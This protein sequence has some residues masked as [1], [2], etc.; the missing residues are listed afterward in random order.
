M[1]PIEIIMLLCGI[2]FLILSFFVGNEKMSQHP[3]TDADLFSAEKIEGLKKDLENSLTE[4]AD[5]LIEDAK[6]K[7]ASAS[8][9]TIISIDDFSKQTLERITHNHEEVVFMYNMLQNK[10]EELKKSTEEFQKSLDEFEIKK[11]AI[12]D[13]MLVM[14]ASA[15]SGIEMAR[16]KTASA[17]V[18]DETKKETVKSAEKKATKTTNRKPVVKTSGEGKKDSPSVETPVFQTETT[19][20]TEDNKVQKIL[21]LHRNRK[22]VLEISKALGLGQGEV[23]LVIDLYG[24]N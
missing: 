21:E 9:E 19:E 2:A 8:N 10:E 16:R 17:K 5:E 18:T 23:K 11:S 15:E 20:L 12:K 22:S 6:N 4:T 14:T 1:G 13:D 7:L 24:K 3:V